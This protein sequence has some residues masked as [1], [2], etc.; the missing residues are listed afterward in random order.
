MLE[1]VGLILLILAVVFW[2]PYVSRTTKFGAPFVP[3]E[4]EV[5]EEVMKL[6]EIK[7]DDIF[8][9]LGSGDGR[10][11]IAAALRGA[12]EVY[13]IEIDT[14]RVF[15]SRLWLK[16]LRLKNAKIIKADFRKVDLSR[17]TVVNMFLLQSTNEELKSKLQKELKKGTRV[18]SE[19]FTL[20]GWKLVKVS[21]NGPIYGPIYLY[22]V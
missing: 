13:G 2:V 1:V 6:A 19:A 18:I 7:K 8:Y 9:D 21:P 22:A 10:V 17:A 12:K 20:P 14:L 16:L 5:I 3:L 15:Y 4:P 11:V